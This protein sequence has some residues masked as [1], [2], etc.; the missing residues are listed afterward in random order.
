MA[1]LQEAAAA[2]GPMTPDLAAAAAQAGAPPVG[3]E[4]GAGAPPPGAAAGAPT[5]QPTPPAAGG[6]PTPAGPGTSPPGA[7]PPGADPRAGAGAGA[8]PDTALDSYLQQ[9]DP[10][11]QQEYERAMRGVAKVLYGTDNTANAIVDQIR[12]GHH[13]SDTAKVSM[14][15]IKEL[16]RKI[17]MDE[18]VVASVTQEAVE[19]ISE[20]AEARHRIQY[21]PSDMEKILGATWEG[22]QSMFGNEDVQGYIQ[23]VQGMNPNDL[24]A[25][26]DY[27][28]GILAQGQGGPAPTPA[29]T[30]TP[31]AEAA[32]PAPEQGMPPTGA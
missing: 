16:D 18:A 31:A 12:P 2:G 1:R 32:T 13:V 24:A 21:T 26:K 14:L 28:E 20:L 11:E 3:A 8:G 6:A 25:L 15:F 23:T 5:P 10:R 27:Q 29:P 9:A 22:V 4:A 7:P 17:N 30:T 19:R